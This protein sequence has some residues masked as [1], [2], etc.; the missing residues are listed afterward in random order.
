MDL[1]IAEVF[2]QLAAEGVATP[3]VE[4][5]RAQLAS[6]MSEE[7]PWYLRAAVGSGAWMA[8]MF[9]LSFFFAIALL[10]QVVLRVVFGV[11]LVVGAI[12][13]RRG[14]RSEFLKHAAVAACL[15]GQFVLLY[16]VARASNSVIATGLF[17]VVMS[18]V[19]VR[20]MPDR[21]HRFLSALFAPFAF[22]AVLLDAQGRTLIEPGFLAVAAV[23]AW[24]W[25]GRVR[26]RSE[27]TAEML[28]PVGYGLVVAVFAMLVISLAI[29]TG[30][31][32]VRELSR[33]R[34]TGALGR[35]TTI[36]LTLGLVALVWNIMD[37]LGEAQ[38]STIAFAAVSGAVILGAG[39]LSS[40]GIVAGIAVLILA[41]DRRNVVLLGMAVL[42][43]LVFVAAYYYNL[44][45]TLLEKSGVLA[46]SG[47]LL[48]GIR[49]RLVPGKPGATP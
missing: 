28:E 1:T 6:R 45:L 30:A 11:G 31:D 24:V 23:T 15:A 34:D 7:M 21:V 35:I 14:T 42:F 22:M 8:T 49:G 17:A 40:P 3:D 38:N 43:L 41:F 29:V 9:L 10:D 37:E 12:V 44:D 32:L 26:E 18:V 46:G 19:L 20:Y 13:V 27:E 39:A 48:I 36:G 4:R 25:R 2:A 5:A 47:L 33:S 16:S